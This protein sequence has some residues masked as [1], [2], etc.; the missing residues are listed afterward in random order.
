MRIAVHVVLAFVLVVLVG[1]LWRLTPFE[2]A[3][4]DV[5]LLCAL[6]LGASSR[7]PVAAATLGAIVIGYLADVVTGAPPGLGS[8]V[9]GAVC[10]LARM[11][12][13]RILFR[14]ALPVAV[15]TF[16][17]AGAAGLATWAIRAAGGLGVG[18][19]AREIAA[20]L[21]SAVLTA[22]LSPL[23]FRV[24]RVVDARFARTERERAAV[25]EGY[26]L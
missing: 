7:N 26:L 14:G 8:L 25:R 5:A 18:P 11:L 22:F 10:V 19:F 24:S 13:S 3:A 21:G 20:V 4:P 6:F 15:L 1:A 16:I 2:V 12:S 17:A 23:V 9:L